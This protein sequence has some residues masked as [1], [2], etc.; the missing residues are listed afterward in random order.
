M[1][2]ALQVVLSAVILEGQSIKKHLFLILFIIFILLVGCINL[3]VS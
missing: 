2:S 1:F 3:K